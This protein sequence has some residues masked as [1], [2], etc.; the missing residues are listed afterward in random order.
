MI[1]F[2]FAPLGPVMLE[3]GCDI[4]YPLSGSFSVGTMYLGTTLLSVVL[5]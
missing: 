1:G 4:V 3:F 2:S 5:A